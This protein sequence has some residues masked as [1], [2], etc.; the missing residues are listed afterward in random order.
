MT[1]FID[2]DTLLHVSCL[3]T[4]SLRHSV[5]NVFGGD[6]DKIEK[7]LSALFMDVLLAAVSFQA[8]ETET[9]KTALAMACQDLQ[10]IFD[11]GFELKNT[12]GQNAVFQQKKSEW[13]EM[14]QRDTFEGIFKKHVS[15]ILKSGDTLGDDVARA[16]D[17]KSF[18]NDLQERAVPPNAPRGGGAGTKDFFDSKL[19]NENL[20]NENLFNGNLFNGKQFDNSMNKLGRDMDKLGE[21]MDKMF[22][23]LHTDK[24]FTDFLG[25]KKQLRAKKN[26]PMNDSEKRIEEE[27]QKKLQKNRFK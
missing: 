22:S 19:F 1:V 16:V 3:H 9:A 10:A 21:D 24:F 20:F 25:E 7:G 27:L 23:S 18:L 26:K 8:I 5:Y 12:P 15:F 2:R 13:A 6:M 14:L 11:L 4:A 17:Y